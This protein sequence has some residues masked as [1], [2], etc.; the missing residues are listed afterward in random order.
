M[1]TIRNRHLDKLAAILTCLILVFGGAVPASAWEI[2]SGPLA[3]LASLE[4]AVY[5]QEGSGSVLQRLEQL[6]SDILGL[7]QEGPIV[8]RLEKLNTAL[9]GPGESLLFRLSA[10][11]WY[12][13]RT[14]SREPLAVRL[15]QVERV[16]SGQAGAGPLGPR[17]DQLASLTWPDGKAGG[18][19]VQ[20]EQG[21]LVKIKLGT[22]LNSQ[23]SKIGDK[24]KFQV[25]Q[26]VKVE[27][28]L[29]F[30]AGTLGEGR[31]TEVVSAGNLGRD[32]RV[33]V[34]FGSLVALDG[35]AF[36]VAV[37]EKATEMNKSLQ[38]AAGASMAGVLLL[39]PVGLV[40][41]YFVRGKDVIIPIGTEFFV[42]LTTSAPATGLSLKGLK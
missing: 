2:A 27:G 33:Q 8:G 3:G 10:L 23:T 29:I 34:D 4:K 21:T 6:E 41:G 5:G 26:D 17:L 18:E 15:A 25:A 40:G 1:T 13:T 32:G 35:Q 28:K 11:E 16:M 20:L 31:V 24:V 19:P 12:L 14:V 42:S 7:K 22:E 39:G 37:D 38:V 9:R 30:P 36:P